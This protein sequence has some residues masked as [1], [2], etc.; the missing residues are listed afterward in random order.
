MKILCSLPGS[1][2]LNVCEWNETRLSQGS[3]ERAGSEKSTPVHGGV[4]Q[5]IEEEITPRYGRENTIMRG[6][7]G[8]GR[9]W[10]GVEL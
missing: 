1:W 5:T 2:F 3:Y 6:R 8:Y 4:E 9:R 10:A 7:V